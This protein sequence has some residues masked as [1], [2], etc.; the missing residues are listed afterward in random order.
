MRKTHQ[1]FFPEAAPTLESSTLGERN[2]V[3]QLPG[4]C[5]CSFF[6]FSACESQ[7]QHKNMGTILTLRLKEIVVFFVPFTESP[8]EHALRNWD[9]GSACS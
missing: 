1:K 2:L 4:L 5:S 6:L 3:R 8:F 9:S 7:T